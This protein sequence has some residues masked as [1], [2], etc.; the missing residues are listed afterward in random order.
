MYTSCIYF[1]LDI[2]RTNFSVFVCVSL[3][4]YVCVCE[5]GGG[6][7]VVAVV[8]VGGKVV[9][10][11]PLIK[12]HGWTNDNIFRPMEAI[13]IRQEFSASFLIKMG[14]R[15]QNTGNY[16]RAS[17]QVQV[18]KCISHRQKDEQYQTVHFGLIVKKGCGQFHTNMPC[19]QYK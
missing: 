14:N 2:L 4:A 15:C 5:R 3:F 18:H 8:A 6:V 11:G 19:V 17:S 10:Y 7:A 16:T 1:S 9:I 12:I 13:C